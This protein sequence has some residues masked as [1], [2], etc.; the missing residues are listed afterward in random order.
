[1]VQKV[2]QVFFNLF[3]QLFNFLLHVFIINIRVNFPCSYSSNGELPTSLFDASFFLLGG[4]RFDRN[5]PSAMAI[6]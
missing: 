6:A 2:S 1:M 4:V 3:H 5:F